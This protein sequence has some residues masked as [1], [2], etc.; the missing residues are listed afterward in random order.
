MRVTDTFLTVVAGA[1]VALAPATAHASPSSA[2]NAQMLHLV[3]EN[4]MEY[5]V[6]SP[7]EASYAALVEDGHRVGVLKGVNGQMFTGVPASKLTTCQ[8]YL[9]G[10][11][12]FTAHVLFTPQG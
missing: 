7:V 5:D 11:F 1:A 4:G 12:F 10:E 2:P 9:D 6:V 8:T 3:C